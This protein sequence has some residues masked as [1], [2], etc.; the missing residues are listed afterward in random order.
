M[1]KNSLPKDELSQL[2]C[3]FGIQYTGALF[4]YIIN[5]VLESRVTVSPQFYLL[6]LAVTTKPYPGGAGMFGGISYLPETWPNLCEVQ[7]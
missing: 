5:P 1:E 4:T 2:I 7:Y 6:T 3:F